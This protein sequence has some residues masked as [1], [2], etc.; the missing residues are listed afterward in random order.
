M[1]GLKTRL[2][3]YYSVPPARV[4]PL[5]RNAERTPTTHACTVSIWISYG[6]GVPYGKTLP[7]IRQQNSGTWCAERHFAY[8]TPLSLVGLPAVVVG[9]DMYLYCRYLRVF[10]ENEV[11]S[12]AFPECGR[13]SPACRKANF[14]FQALMP[15]YCFD[16]FLPTRIVDAWIGEAWIP[17]HGAR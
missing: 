7:W 2:V 10:L 5:P 13:F 1:P 17:C 15:I 3:L 6:C 11:A 9:T 14:I 8:C 16:S 4:F 12:C